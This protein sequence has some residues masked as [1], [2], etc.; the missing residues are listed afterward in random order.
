MNKKYW[1]SYFFQEDI[2]CGVRRQAIVNQHPLLIE[3]SWPG[4]KPLFLSDFKEISDDVFDR[5]YD[6]PKFR[7]P[8]PYI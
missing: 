6:F 8:N 1:M 4:Q 2:T 7:L 3:N 5:L